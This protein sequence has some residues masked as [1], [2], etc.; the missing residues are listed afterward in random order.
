MNNKQNLQ[1][2]NKQVSA[3]PTVQLVACG[4]SRLPGQLLLSRFKA[5]FD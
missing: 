2:N 3:P 5:R 4:Y 1:M